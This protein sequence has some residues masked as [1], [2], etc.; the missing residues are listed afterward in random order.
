MSQGGLFNIAPNTYGTIVKIPIIVKKT[1]FAI[2]AQSEGN[3]ESAIQT[4]STWHMGGADNKTAIHFLIN[5]LLSYQDTMEWI[6]ICI[7]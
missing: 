7:S 1:L 4:F 3:T 6:A 2:N 5:R